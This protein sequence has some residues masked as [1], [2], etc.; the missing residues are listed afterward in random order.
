[1]GI[2]DEKGRL[3][4]RVNIVD[5][6]I[7]LVI[8]ALAG[9]VAYGRILDYVAPAI[10]AEKVEI[11]VELLVSGV[12]QAT[13]DVLQPGTNLYHT[14]TNAYL[15][16]LTDLRIEP[17]EIMIQ[18]PDGGIIE[19]TSAIRYDVYMTVKGPARITERVILLGN[20]EIRVGTRVPLQSR[21]A[22]V[23]ATVMAI[24]TD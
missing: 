9:R 2:L 14:Q 24:R 20:T 4:G 18:L 15:G 12:R 10:S 19:S 16:V 8:V 5:L 13:I 7:I 1:M 21:L 17:A 22:S 23:A 3:F 6:L 11:E